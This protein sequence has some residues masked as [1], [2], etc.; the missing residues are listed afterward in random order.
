[1]EAEARRKSRVM[2]VF[3]EVKKDAISD[4]IERWSVAT[5]SDV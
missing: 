2:V 1:M 5:V 4:M 3:T